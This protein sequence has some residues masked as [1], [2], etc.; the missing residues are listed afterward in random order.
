M[1]AIRFEKNEAPTVVRSDFKGYFDFCTEQIGCKIPEHVR[2]MRLPR[3]YAMIIDDMGLVNDL[4]I[5]NLG[6]IL[7]GTDQHGSPICGPAIILKDVMTLDGP[8]TVSLDESD[9]PK[10]KAILNEVLAAFC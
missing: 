3:P 1:L 4:P 9:I 5:N 6:S 8:S 10:V 7:Y 2:P